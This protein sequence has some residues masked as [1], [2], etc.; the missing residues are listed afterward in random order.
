V[1]DSLAIAAQ[2]LVGAALGS[3]DE[4]GA[5]SLAWQVTRYGLAFGIALGLMFAAIEPVLPQLF[6][7]D[8]AVL[9][10]IPHAWWF[11]VALQPVAGVVF[12]LDGVLL[13]AGDAAFLRTSTLVS[14]LVGFL[15]MVWASLV[16]GWGL[17]GIW[18]GLAA[19][20]LLRLGFVLARTYGTRWSVTGAVR[21]PGRIVP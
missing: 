5:R 18:S 20:M 6:T 16:F 2:S 21:H 13:G 3:G 14:A 11:F 10:E 7:S 17:I 12:A 1:L 4:R 9:A 15:P 19:F 8:G